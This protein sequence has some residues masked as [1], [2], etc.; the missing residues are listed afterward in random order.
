MLFN[1]VVEWLTT[2]LHCRIS[3]VAPHYAFS[4]YTLYKLHSICKY[5]QVLD[6]PRPKLAVYPKHP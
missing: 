3:D 1:A 4:H 5:D 6:S 2:V